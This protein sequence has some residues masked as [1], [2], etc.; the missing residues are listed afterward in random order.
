MSL[1]E[2]DAPVSSTP[3]PMTRREAREREEAARSAQAK[4]IFTS[5]A[6]SRRE[7]AAQAHPAA[8]P[9]AA[10]KP[11]PAAGPAKKHH[12]GSRLLSLGALLF[13]GTLLVAVSVPANAF[14]SDASAFAPATKAEVRQGQSLVVADDVAAPDLTRDGYSVTS[15]AQLLRQKYG[16]AGTFTATTGAIRWPFPYSV[17]TTDGFGPR[18]ISISGRSFHNG[19]DFTP[20]AGTP[21]YAIADGVVTLHANDYGGLGNNVMIS[22]VINGQNIDSVYAHMQEDS[23]PLVV[24]ETIKV[25]DFVGL[26][27][28]T[29]TSYG[30][31]LH[32]ELHVDKVPVDPFAWLTANAVN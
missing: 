3:A 30:S 8:T 19:V 28:D 4:A 10:A 20:G 15:Y 31:H 7:S 24:G 18:D 25:G 1:R 26:V 27:G 14:M 29:G 9:R 5:A 11:R 13:A 17:P 22:H 2:L 16:N 32:F 6:P 12:T 21:I 23:S